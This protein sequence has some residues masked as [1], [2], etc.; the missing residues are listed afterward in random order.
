MFR[1]GSALKFVLQ[2]RSDVCTDKHAFSF[3]HRAKISY[4]LKLL[5]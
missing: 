4:M 3:S 5:N 2:F 1:L